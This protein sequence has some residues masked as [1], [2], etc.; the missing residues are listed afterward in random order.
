MGLNARSLTVIEGR[1]LHIVEAR[2]LAQ[3]HAIPADSLLL[4]LGIH[5]ELVCRA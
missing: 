1:S 4:W 5:E 2:L 3:D